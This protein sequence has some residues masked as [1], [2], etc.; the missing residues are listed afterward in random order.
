M[1]TPAL[2]SFWEGP[3]SWIERLCV[4]SVLNAGHRLTIYTYDPQM[5]RKSGIEGDICDAREVLAECTV[6]SFRSVGRHALFS[7]LFRLE[8]QRQNKGIWVDLDCY[9]LKPLL[10]TSDYVFGL[11]IPGKLNGAVL[12][13]PLGCPMA[14]EYMRAITTVPLRTPWATWR[15]RLVREAEILLGKPVP[16]PSKQTN[17]GPRALTHF[18]TRYGLMKYA[19]AQ[20]VFYPIATND[21]CLLVQPDDRPVHRSIREDTLIVHLWHGQLKKLGFT[22]RLPPK[23]SYL[24]IVLSAHSVSL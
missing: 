19:V 18:A 6:E 14:E 15:R 12:G 2:V 7:D 5:L 10:P 13:L 9:F 21:A 8:L 4:R 16:H 1:N 22:E 24:G 23:G 3:I 11:I 17:I 20:H